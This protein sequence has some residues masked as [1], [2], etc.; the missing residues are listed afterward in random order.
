MACI[1]YG[2]VRDHLRAGSGAGSN[3]YVACKAKYFSRCDKSLLV[4]LSFIYLFKEHREILSE[5]RERS[6][7]HEHREILSELRERSQDHEHREILSELRERSQDHEHREILSEL[8]E[9]SRK[10]LLLKKSQ[11]FKFVSVGR[12]RLPPLSLTYKCEF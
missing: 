2:Q 6:Q 12:N 8:R 1:R 7:D 10:L 4:D 5:L 9:R 3:N 11:D